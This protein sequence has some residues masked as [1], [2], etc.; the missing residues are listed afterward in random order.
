VLLAIAL[1]KLFKA[2]VLVA[3][4]VGALTLLGHPSDTVTRLRELV[5]EVGI[6]PNHRLLNRAIGAVSGL[7]AKRL[8]E[9]GVGTFAYAAVFLVEGTGLLLRKQWAEYLTTLVT[10]SFVPFEIYH[11]IRRPSAW[12][13]GGIAVNVLIVVYLAV[14]LWRQRRAAHRQA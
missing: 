1:F 9:V 4:G 7:D 11:L 10:A 5:R 6:D 14:R 13:I 3:I 8:E 12:K 2:V